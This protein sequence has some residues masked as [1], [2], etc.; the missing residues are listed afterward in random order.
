MKDARGRTNLERMKK[1]LAPLGPDGKHINLHHTTQINENS[2]AEVTQ[3]R[4]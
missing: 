2:I 1:G 3:V 4:I